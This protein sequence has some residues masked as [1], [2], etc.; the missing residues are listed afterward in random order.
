MTSDSES[1]WCD[2]L[3]IS[4][5]TKKLFGTTTF[6]DV[7]QTCFKTW[8]SR[9]LIRGGRGWIVAFQG[10]NPICG[11]QYALRLDEPSTA[12]GRVEGGG[13]PVLSFEQCFIYF[14]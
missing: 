13:Q 12:P 6:G 8:P 11:P 9:S 4:G 7:V 10:C 14:L 5:K 2:L 3:N 1:E